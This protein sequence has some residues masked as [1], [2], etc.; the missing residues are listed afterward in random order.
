MRSETSGIVPE[1]TQHYKVPFNLR[2]FARRNSAQ[3]GILGV[4]ILL[5][6]LFIISAPK[7]FLAPQI[8]SAFMESIPFFAII[9]IPLTIVVISGEM[10]LSFPSVMGM[11]MVAFYFTYT[12]TSFVHNPTIQVFLAILA[13]LLMGTLVGWINGAI[14]VY[15]GIPSLVVTIGTQ[16]LWRGAV[17]V[18][19]QGANYS[20]EFIKGTIFYPMLVGKIG[21][22]FPAQMIWLIVITILG[23]LL[24]N[25]HSFGAHIYLIGDNR[26]SAELMGVDTKRTR[27][28]AFMLIGMLSAFAGVVASFYVAYFWPS[29]GD[30]YL[31]STMASVY[32]GGTS[33]IG[34]T[35]TILGTFLGAFIIG[36]IEAATVAVGLTGFWTQFIYGL[37]I[38]LSVIMHQYLRKRAD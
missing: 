2:S 12:W 19:T 33:V 3:L 30:G 11:G 34:G 25:R 35:G 31:L 7:T 8:Y 9:A 37:I 16:F 13:A 26:N 1:V 32:L 27:I 38:V 21:G 6:L 17:L 36:A 23:W 18:L 14:I 28:Q 22:Y 5:W 15:F 4:F 24:L 29:L 10:D 20:L